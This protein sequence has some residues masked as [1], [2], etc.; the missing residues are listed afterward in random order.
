MRSGFS[1]QDVVLGVLQA[2]FMRRMLD[3]NDALEVSHARACSEL[4]AFMSLLAAEGWRL[5]Q[6]SLSSSERRTFSLS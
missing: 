1:S 5:D 2:A 4:H 6:V 3:R